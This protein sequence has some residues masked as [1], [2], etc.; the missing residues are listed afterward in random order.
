[1][2]LLTPG[3]GPPSGGPPSARADLAGP[4]SAW[5]TSGGPTSARPISAGPTSAGPTSARPTSAGQPP[6]GRPQRGQSQRGQPQGATLRGATL[7]GAKLSGADLSEADLSEADL[8]GAD[9]READLRWANLSEAILREADLR[10]AILSKA[11]LRGATLSKAKLRGADLRA[12]DLRGA[13]LSEA[14]LR[15]ADLS[16]AQMGGTV[17]CSLV[18]E[19]QGIGSIQHDGPSFISTDTLV[20]SKGR[21]PVSFLRGCGLA[22]WEV[23]NARLYDPNL[24]PSEIEELLYKVFDKRTHGP[25]FI[26]GLFI[27]HSWKNSD[28]VDMLYERLKKEGANVWLDRHHAVAGPLQKQIDRAIRLNDVVLIVLSKAAIESDWVENELEMA[29]KKEKEEKRDVLCP[30]ALD[31]SWKS[32]LEP[33]EPYRGLWRTLTQKNVL[34]FSKW[35]SGEFESTYE[36]LIRG[37]KIYYPPADKSATSDPSPLP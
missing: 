20:L 34:D 33:D 30:I 13:I 10:G 35:D 16:E 19:V 22:P 7:S 14:K 25:I 11:K 21:I 9:L 8:S 2:T 36:K 27:S 31:D 18:S 24:T 4:I 5:P 28:F 6:R 32:K 3:A 29:R 15:G 12:A 37:L 1:M 17:L 23:L 26:G